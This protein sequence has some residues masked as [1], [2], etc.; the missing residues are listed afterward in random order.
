MERRSVSEGIQILLSIPVCLLSIFWVRKNK[1]KVN[2]I[3]LFLKITFKS[4]YV[5]EAVESILEAIHSSIL[6]LAY[7]KHI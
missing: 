6:S 4:E 7:H 5:A 2:Q 3:S 1:D